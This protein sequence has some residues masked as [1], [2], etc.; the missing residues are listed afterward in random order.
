M[1]LKSSMSFLDRYFLVHYCSCLTD[2]V[3][4]RSSGNT[5][6]ATCIC[7][8]ECIKCSSNFFS[9]FLPSIYLFFI[10]TLEY[11]CGIDQCNLCRLEGAGCRKYSSFECSSFGKNRRK[12]TDMIHMRMC[13]NNSR[14]SISNLFDFS[15][16]FSSSLIA[17][18]IYE[19]TEDLTFNMYLE[20]MTRTTEV[21]SRF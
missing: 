12:V 1:F 6:F 4:F 11:F 10:F 19:D 17:S 9:S 16:E 15:F 8:F 21:M 14:N 20:F 13:Q 3:S 2:S 5:F 18:D 7:T